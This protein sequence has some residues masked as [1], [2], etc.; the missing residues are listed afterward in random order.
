MILSFG[1]RIAFIAV[2]VISLLF[3]LPALA[4]VFIDFEDA[5][6]GTPATA[7]AY[8]GVTFTDNN[9]LI[10]SS[11]PL[12]SK[13][14]F[15]PCGTS[16]TINFDTPQTSG[17]FTW[18][19]IND[20]LI[21]EVLL[22]GN[23]V[24]TENFAGPWGS[25]ATINATFDQLIIDAGD[26]SGCAAIDDL[27]TI[28]AAVA[29]GGGIQPFTDGRINREDLAAPVVLYAN[30]GGLDIYSATGSGLIFS[31]SASE[32]AAV[33]ACPD[34]NTVIASEAGITLSRLTARADGVCPFQ[35]NAPTATP[36]KQYIII[37]DTLSSATAYTS[38]EQ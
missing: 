20:Q 37:F 11:L 15:G 14:I 32:I 27:N 18:A 13:H 6:D 34:T 31:V 1:K 8:P 25:L 22:G 38:Y 35:L 19:S 24:T 36:G 26:L 28:G 29:S 4:N 2:L 12:P 9:W 21:V 30:N 5:V 3:V 10:S 23:P 17:S 33:A 7:L 16:L